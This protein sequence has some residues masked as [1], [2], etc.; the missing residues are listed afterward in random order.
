M[1]WGIPG[2]VV[3]VNG[4]YAKVDVGGT[5]V[6]AVLGVEDVGVGDYVVVHAGLVVGKLSREEFIENL[7]TLIELQVMGYVDE[8]LTEPEAR[9]RVL[10]EFKDILNSFG[11][12][13]NT[14][15]RNYLLRT[16]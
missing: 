13:L 2:R 6:D 7:L 12:D 11:V 10:K 15:W 16:S 9:E 1:C 14:Y 8:G 5:L 3:E 4:M